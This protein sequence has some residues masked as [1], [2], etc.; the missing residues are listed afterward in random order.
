MPDHSDYPLLGQVGFLVL[1]IL[2]LLKEKQGFIYHGTKEN[3]NK[4]LL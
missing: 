1:R 3:P 4:Y 2:C